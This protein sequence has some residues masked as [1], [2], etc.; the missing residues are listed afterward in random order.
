MKVVLILILNLTVLAQAHAGS[1]FRGS[2]FRGS[3]QAASQTEA[4]TC[5]DCD[6]RAFQGRPLS[7]IDVNYVSGGGSLR[8][9]RQQYEYFAARNA[10][11][12]PTGN[13]K[14]Y[15]MISDL[16]R[17]TGQ[18]LSHIVEVDSAGKVKIVASFW[19]GEGQG[20][21]NE[22]GSNMSPRGFMQMGNSDYRPDTMRTDMNGNRVMS[23]WPRC[24]QRNPNF[25]DNRIMLHG[26]EPGFNDNLSEKNVA[27][28]PNNPILCRDASGQVTPR[29]AR[30]HAIS[31]SAGNTTEGCKGLPMDAW[32][33]WG[34]KLSGGCAYNYDG[35]P[36]PATRGM[37]G[38]SL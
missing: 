25:Q 15:G 3:P 4:G 14:K 19:A 2:W 17:G 21:G 1:I 28:N 33:E 11:C 29:Y 13:E 8:E 10:Q 5:T 30:L 37:S 31:Y 7:A 9:A 26:L 32:C 23:S 12:R 20:V 34:P 6:R 24:G 27:N 18:N 35:H 22:C 16:S 36:T 38:T